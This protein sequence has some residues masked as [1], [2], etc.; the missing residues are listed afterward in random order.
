M[1]YI[2]KYYKEKN[3]D[4]V[5]TRDSSHFL[6]VRLVYVY[7]VEIIIGPWNGGSSIDS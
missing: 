5:D 6:V 2:K 4:T 1:N 3:L 7:A